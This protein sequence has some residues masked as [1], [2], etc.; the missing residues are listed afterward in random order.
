[1]EASLE[2]DAQ[3][4]TVSTRPQA[5]LTAAFCALYGVVALPLVLGHSF[6][7]ALGIASI[8]LAGV[9]AVLSAID[10]R[11]YRLPDLL[12]LPLV[13]LGLAVAWWLD[14]GPLLWRALSAAIGFA[15]LAAMGE[16]YRR[17]RGQAGLG[18]G[19][20]KLLAA[21]GA[22]VGGEGLPT[23]LIWATGSAIAVVGVAHLSGR[24]VTPTTRIPFGPFLALATWVVWLYGPL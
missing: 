11:E 10:V 12:T 16:I 13:A 18:L 1:M 6:S 24:T 20:A 23:V 19:D 9:L 4:D 8:A 21:A 7:L 5:W 2:R 3:T 15:I 14:L 17:L 22:W